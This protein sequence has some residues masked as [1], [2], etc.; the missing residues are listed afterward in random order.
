MKYVYELVPTLKE[1]IWA[2]SKLKKYKETNLKKIS[3]SW[4]FSFID[5]NESR[6][7]FEDKEI[8]LSNFL[9]QL[10]ISS[11]A[12]NP[13]IKA[14]LIKLIDSD[15]SLSIQVHPNDKYALLNEGSLG[16]TEMWII[17]EAE[18]DS[19]LYIG[20]NK[21][22][23]KTNLKNLIKS[24]EILTKLNK[25]YVNPGDVFMIKPGTI[26]AI[27]KGITLLEIQ[28]S[29]NLTY[30]VYDFNRVDKNGNKRELH[31]K[32]AM[33]VLNFAKFNVENLKNEKEIKTPYFKVEQKRS[34]DY[35]D[36]KVKFV[37]IV[38]IIDGKGTIDDVIV[39]K[40]KSYL[41]LPS[42]KLDLNGDFRFVITSA[43]F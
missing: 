15:D 33:D 24:D 12:V 16:K 34:L 4:E 31:V 39:Q 20:F 37:S 13:R 30:R 18:K 41:L 3:E 17:L 26:H 11:V 9:D 28:E 22:I 43:S 42:K 5:G 6:V 2:G 14:T 29:S 1:Y 27:G 7:K 36:I 8:L 25:I 10:L 32:K 23:D 38:T 21:D 35:K 40:Y 19:Y